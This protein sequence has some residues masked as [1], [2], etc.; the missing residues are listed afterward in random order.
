LHAAGFYDKCREE[1]CSDYVVSS[2]T[3]TLAALLRAQRSWPVINAE[4]SSLALVAAP[5]AHN[6]TLPVLHS[7]H[8]EMNCVVS[9]AKKAHVSMNEYDFHQT[10]TLASTSD[11]LISSTFAHIAC[12]GIQHPTDPLS[13]GFCLQDGNLTVSQLME[14]DLKDSFLAFLSACETA[15]GDWKQPDQTVNLAAT[16]LFVGFR[17]VVATMW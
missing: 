12:H 2:C 17:S 8:E 16:M 13:S 14:L 6:S 1:C 11:S 5:K 3:P 7:V 15:K 10:A 9:A 4:A